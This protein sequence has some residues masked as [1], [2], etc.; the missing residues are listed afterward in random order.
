MTLLNVVLAT[1]G[2]AVEKL[3]LGKW[4]WQLQNFATQYF[5]PCEFELSVKNVIENEKGR[6]HISRYISFQNR[7]IQKCYPVSKQLIN[8]KI[9]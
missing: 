4:F 1:G 6:E 7:Q 2:V 5:C 8:F 9:T 3:L